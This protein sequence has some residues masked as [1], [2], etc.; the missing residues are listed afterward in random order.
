[1]NSIE[2]KRMAVPGIEVE[3][4][5]VIRHPLHNALHNKSEQCQ[6]SMLESA[7][8]SFINDVFAIEILR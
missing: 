5:C 6:R 1:M 7:A 4:I 8:G 2:I 3:E